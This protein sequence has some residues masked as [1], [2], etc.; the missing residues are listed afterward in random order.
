MSIEI[1]F[2]RA[3]PGVEAQHPVAPVERDHVDSLVAGQHSRRP[4]MASR[5]KLRTHQ[6]TPRGVGHPR[7]LIRS[8]RLTAVGQPDRVI[9]GVTQG[10]L[11]ISFLPIYLAPI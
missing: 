7:H 3:S 4:A 1:V 5:G 2:S 6:P 11:S 10:A 9:V 8:G